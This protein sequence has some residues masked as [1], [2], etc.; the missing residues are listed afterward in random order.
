MLIL[1]V[2]ACMH[3]IIS[4]GQMQMP[5]S[6]TLEK[7]RNII[8]FKKYYDILFRSVKDYVIFVK[9]PLS[10]VQSSLSEK[11]SSGMKN[12]KLQTILSQF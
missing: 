11:L 10:H 1:L 6:M 8:I 12:S 7:Q 2:H 4:S 9:I 5:I 3:L